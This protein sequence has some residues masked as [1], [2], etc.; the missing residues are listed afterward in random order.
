LIGN[1]WGKTQADVGLQIMN[2]QDNHTGNP[3]PKDKFMT[4]FVEKRVHP[5]LMDRDDDNNIVGDGIVLKAKRNYLP[6]YNKTEKIEDDLRRQGPF[7][8]NTSDFQYGTRIGYEY[9]EL[10]NADGSETEPAD[11]TIP[12]KHLFSYDVYDLHDKTTDIK[13]ADYSKRRLFPIE[14][15][16]V[17]NPVQVIID[18]ERNYSDIHEPNQHKHIKY[19][20]R[21][22]RDPEYANAKNQQGEFKNP[23]VA[24]LQDVWAPL[25]NPNAVDNTPRYYHPLG[26]P[27]Y[28]EARTRTNIG[29]FMVTNR[30]FK[31]Q[32]STVFFVINETTQDFIR[33]ELKQV[34]L[35]YHDTL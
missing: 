10:R 18:D 35:R 26:M 12:E 3:L 17:G 8:Y 29:D 6:F 1:Y 5:R 14:D 7:E 33:V 31:H 24:G 28:L 20:K 16:A 34:P 27:M 15:F 19:V 25:L 22:I 2:Y 30:N 9:I 23:A 21:W 4:F 11:K 13:T 32:G